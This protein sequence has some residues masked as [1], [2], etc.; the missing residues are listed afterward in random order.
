MPSPQCSCRTKGRHYSKKKKTL[1]ISVKLM[2]K[3]FTN[4]AV[5]PAVAPTMA[6]P[7]AL[8][9][10]AI[11]HQGGRCRSV[12]SSNLLLLHSVILIS[13]R[14]PLAMQL[15][16]S[17]P[18]LHSLP[19]AH[20]QPPPTMAATGVVSTR[21]TLLLTLH[22]LSVAYSSSHRPP[23]RSLARCQPVVCR[24]CCLRCTDSRSVAHLQPPTTVAGA[25]AGAMGATAGATAGATPVV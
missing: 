14:T 7:T 22:P 5:V 9:P 8:A 20:L 10:P 12:D 25:T 1:G 3:N 13:R 24:C 18:S 2:M 16:S 6:A 11:A 23:W 19:V 21:R 15:L 4:A 17:L